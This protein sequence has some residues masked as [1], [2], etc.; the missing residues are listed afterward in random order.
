M[1]QWP[2]TDIVHNLF[3]LFSCSLSLLQQ[4]SP[5]GFKPKQSTQT[6]MEAPEWPRRQMSCASSLLVGGF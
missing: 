2:L 6:L 4:P 1:P 5:N 3:F